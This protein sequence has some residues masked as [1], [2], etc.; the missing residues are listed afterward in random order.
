MPSATT[1][2][3]QAVRRFNRLYTR[4]LGLLGAHHLE[5]HYGLTEIRVIYELAHREAPTAADLA[6]ALG[7]DRGQLSRLLAKL[8]QQGM[9][10]RTRHPDDKRRTPLALTDAG[11]RL[12]AELDGRADQNV[13]EVLEGLPHASRRALVRAAEALGPVEA[14]APPEVILRDPRPG[15]FGWIIHRHGVLYGLE[16]GWDER[17]EG[18]V[19]EVISKY[20]I[21]HDPAKEKYW[22]AERGGQIIGSVYVVENVP[23]VAQLR[24]L[25]VEPSARGLGIGQRLVRECI[26]FARG[27]GYKTMIL[28][29]HDV[30][31]SAQRI[32]AAEGF[33]LIE[34]K[35]HAE[36]GEGLVG[37]T[38][39]LTL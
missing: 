33:K 15:D 36:F 13:A 35:P 7:L 12:C 5:S 31:V 6:T 16:R 23:G 30:L 2:E 14:Q 10:I 17:F 8:T 38:W 22:I 37:Q 9:V 20:A 4:E 26:A 3:I 18:F 32:Y 25:L 11:R 28:W 27:V 1:V 24:C 21:H 29:T 34:E 19:A 39:E